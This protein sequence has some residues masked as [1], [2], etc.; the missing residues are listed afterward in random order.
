MTEHSKPVETGIG[1][2]HAIHKFR[3]NNKGVAAVEFALIVPILLMMYLGT[4]EISTGITVNK[5]VA[6]VA[7][8]VADLVTQQETVTQAQLEEIMEIGE[9]ILFPYTGSKPTIKIEAID[10]DDDYTGGGK[11]MWTRKLDNGTFGTARPKNEEVWVPERLRIDESFVVLV[12][13][14]M[15]YYPLVTWVTKRDGGGKSV[16]I[17]MKE[18]YWLHP[19]LSDTITCSNC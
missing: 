8:T 18:Q 19:R 13:T 15:T 3:R 5:R 17:P 7:S 2:F 4:M 1:V 6:R 10:V 12:Q 16:G 14:E 9:A 11:I